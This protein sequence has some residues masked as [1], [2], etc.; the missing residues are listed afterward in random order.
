MAVRE[1]TKQYWIDQLSEYWDRGFTIHEYFEL[2]DLSYESARQWI[3][4]FRKEREG[5]G[6]N[7]GH[8]E[9]VEVSRKSLENPAY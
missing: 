2:K 5:H 9:F 4:L 8:L 1:E 7:E 6:N 3:L